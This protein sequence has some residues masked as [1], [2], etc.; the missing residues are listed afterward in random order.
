[1]K[2]LIAIPSC[3]KYDYFDGRGHVVL[4]GRSQLIRNTW[5]KDWISNYQEWADFK[6]FVGA[7]KLSSHMP[8]L[9]RDTLSLNVDDSYAGLP[10][11]VSAIYRYAYQAGYDFVLR[12][13]DDVYVWLD[14]IFEDF[15]NTIDYK[16]FVCHTKDGPYCCGACQWLSRRAIKV[17]IDSPLP[18][19]AFEDRWVGRVLQAAGITP[20]HSDRMRVCHCFECEV[21]YPTVSLVSF[22]I[23]PDL[24]RFYKLGER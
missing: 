12:A 4:P 5:Y 16:G 13:D 18:A 8:S 2:I 19:D 6:F 10:E 1:M 3:H 24:S 11:K 17:I 15:D 22:H 21:K 14:R 7:G 23:W 9:D 20:K